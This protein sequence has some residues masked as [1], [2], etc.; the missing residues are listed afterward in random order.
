MIHTFHR[1]VFSS[2]YVGHWIVPILNLNS[3]ALMD[4]I[5]LSLFIFLYF[6]L[7]ISLY[8]SLSITSAI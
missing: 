2:D 6:Y 8:L 7:S 1:S 4:Y 5:Y 3:Y